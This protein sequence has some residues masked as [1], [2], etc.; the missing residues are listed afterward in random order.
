M[1]RAREEH[2]SQTRKS[3]AE[4]YI[5]GTFSKVLEFQEFYRRGMNALSFFDAATEAAMLDVRLVAAAACPKA[6]KGKG[7]KGAG[8][9]ASTAGDAMKDALHDVLQREAVP[10]GC[11]NDDL[12]QWP[13][14]WSPGGG[15]WCA[16]SPRAHRCQLHPVCMFL[17]SPADLAYGTTVELWS[18]ESVSC[19]LQHA[20]G[21]E[22]V[23]GELRAADEHCRLAL[24]AAATGR[25]VQRHG[26]TG[27][28]GV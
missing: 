7:K 3:I 2:D 21:V 1:L 25:P 24:V 26:R 6:A 19:C 18:C 10:N 20:R 12:R 9:A 14:W 5:N 23:G 17:C 13:A 27:M 8:R 15:P 11:L 4:C 22:L 28:A 16:A